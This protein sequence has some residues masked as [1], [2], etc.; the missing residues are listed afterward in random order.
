MN[1]N[2]ILDSLGRTSLFYACQNGELDVVKKI[3]FSETGTGIFPTRLALI[4]K[5]DKNGFK[6]ADIAEQSNY[7]EIAQLLRDQESR[8]YWKE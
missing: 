1:D 4:E 6:A 8:M 2:F 7:L 5:K 3:I